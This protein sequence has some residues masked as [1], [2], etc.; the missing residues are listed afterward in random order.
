MVLQ[1]FLLGL[2]LQYLFE[3]NN[4]W[5]NLSWLLV[6]IVVGTSAIIDKSKLPFRALFIPVIAGLILGLIP[7][8][9][10]LLLALF[11]PTPIYNAQYL[12]PIAGM[13]L[14]NSLTA[15]IVALQSLFN[16]FTDK[17]EQYQAALSLGAH[18]KIAAFDFARQA[19]LQAM[20]PNLASMSTIG[21][22]SLPGMM[23]GQILSGSSPMT[24]IKYQ[25]VIIAA[26]F[27]MIMVSVA[28]S[29]TLALRLCIS[30]EGRLKVE[31]K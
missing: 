26:I 27:V 14:G 24:A 16:Q 3:L 20:A 22:V 7:L 18:P 10:I 4:L 23:T 28:T 5:L 25:I 29:L 30:A 19:L 21:L 1:L 15:N 6:M 17:F 8:L 11:T 12:I 13:L 2:Y 9:G 31:L